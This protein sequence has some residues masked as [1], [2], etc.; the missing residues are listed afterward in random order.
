MK[1]TSRKTMNVMAFSN[2]GKVML[3]VNGRVVGTQT[4]DEVRT[5]VFRDVPLEVGSNRVSVVSGMLQQ[6]AV[7]VR[8]E[9]DS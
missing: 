9:P 8:T 3:S 7:W 6:D 1:E 4:P 2:V 5:V